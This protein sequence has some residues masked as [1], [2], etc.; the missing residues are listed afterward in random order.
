MSKDS[1]SRWERWARFRFSVIGPVLASPPERGKLRQALEELAQKLYLHPIKEGHRLQFAFST[2]ER[3]YYRAL[4]EADPIAAL[5]RKM[6][7]DMGQTK[8]MS[9]QLLAELERQ[10]KTHP[11]WSYLLHR[12]NLAAL[13]CEKPEL[14]SAPS[15]ATVRRR[16]QE[17]GWLKKRSARRHATTGQKRALKRLARYEVRSF[18]SAYVHALWHLDFHHGRLRIVDAL[19][20]WHTPMALAVLDDCS[21]LCC[22]MQWY[23]SETAATLFHGLGQAFAKR[24]LPRELMTDCGS[25]MLAKETQNGLARLGILH[26]TTL[27]YSP[28][29]NGKQEAFWAQ[30]E[31]RL[32]AMLENV[33]ALSLDF[34][35]RATQAW[36]E[37]EYNRKNHEE[38]GVSPLERLVGR[39]DISRAAPDTETLRQVFSLL[40]KRT[41][42]R[43]DGTI[44]I[45]GIRFEIPSRLRHFRT[46]HIR[47]QSWDLSKVS[48]VDERTGSLLAI[49]YPQDKTRNA[50]GKRRSLEPVFSPDQSLTDGHTSEPIP[51]LMRRLLE[52]YAATGLPPAYLPLK[53]NEETNDE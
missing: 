43:S 9:P 21:R 36:V 39:T 42:R 7:S 25:A 24:G 47:Y 51:P 8:A 5:G 15:Y 1:M 23:V 30:V 46:V 44:S 26:A 11:R 2:I 48:V 33:E 31:G 6:R 13:V 53:E 17:R 10:Y 52:D 41:Q 35:N 28:Y 40:Q 16:M 29:Q 34:L 20:Q 27:P 49:I 45:E 19:G 37:M 3:W 4:G 22:H 38:L 50:D 32:M 14:G 12:D 18:E